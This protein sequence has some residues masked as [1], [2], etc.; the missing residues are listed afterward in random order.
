MEH[1][2]ASF[3]VDTA[4]FF[5]DFWPGKH[6]DANLITPWK[7]LQTLALTSHLLHLEYRLVM[8]NLLIAAS[9]TAY[10]MPNLEVMEIWN[11]AKNCTRVF[12]YKKNDGNCGLS[13]N[14]DHSMRMSRVGLEVYYSWERLPQHNR[15]R[16]FSLRWCWSHDFTKALA[17]SKHVLDPVSYYELAWETSGRCALF[18]VNIKR[19]WS[20]RN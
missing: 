12:R 3:P 8:G 13:W 9:R 18:P 15:Q 4:D 20:L 1:L 19:V 14:G 6:L 11:R 16:N 7:N 5:A 17:L 2:S 10:F